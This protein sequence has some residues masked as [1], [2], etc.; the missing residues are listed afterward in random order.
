MR[1]EWWLL[2]REVDNVIGH[3]DGCVDVKHHS[4]NHV[5]L[6]RRTIFNWMLLYVC[7]CVAQPNCHSLRLILLNVITYGSGVSDDDSI[8]HLRLLPS[9]RNRRTQL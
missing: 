8:E 6:S 1:F 9:R 7:V 2:K 3:L 4:I 5:Q